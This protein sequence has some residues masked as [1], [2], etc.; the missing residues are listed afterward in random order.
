MRHNTPNQQQEPNMATIIIIKG[1]DAIIKSVSMEHANIIHDMCNHFMDPEANP[2]PRVLLTL[3]TLKET[4]QRSF[5]SVRDEAA[6]CL[7]E[8]R[9]HEEKIRGGK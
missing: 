3:Q 8:I 7:E 1:E 2:D 5:E 4:L 6:W 9:A